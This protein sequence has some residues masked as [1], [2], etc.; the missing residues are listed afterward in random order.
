MIRILCLLSFVA[1]LWAGCTPEVIRETPELAGDLF[2]LNY[3]TP[4][5]TAPSL[6]G[7][8]YYEASVRFTKDQ[9][10]AYQGDTLIGVYFFIEEVP[11]ACSVRIYQGSTNGDPSA[12]LEEINLT[13][14]IEPTRWHQ[15]AWEDKG[16]VLGEDDL[17]LAVRFSHANDA[18]T[19]GCDPG[20]ASLDGDWLFD[21][22]DSDWLPLSTRAPQIDIN[23]NIRGVIKPGQ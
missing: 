1:L 10:S 11:D 4:N 20:P 6:P 14:E 21:S 9:L 19:L 15:F 23:W 17:W 13:D 22:Q 3:D 16:I 2:Y 8:G 7:G 12:L 5:Q 18:R